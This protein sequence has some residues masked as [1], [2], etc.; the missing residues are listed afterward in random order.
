M[1]VCATL[2][3]AVISVVS[4]LGGGGNVRAELEHDY[5]FL[6]G[7]DDCEFE[8]VSTPF[9][10]WQLVNGLPLSWRR[11]TGGTPSS[12]TGPSGDAS[13]NFNGGK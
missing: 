13:R 1:R 5:F 12:N 11:V 9:C 7:T 2:T 3:R 8:K 10:H 4:I 6:I